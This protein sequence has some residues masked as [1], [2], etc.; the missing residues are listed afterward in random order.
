[1]KLNHFF[2]YLVHID[3][4]EEFMPVT[5]RK[6]LEITRAGLT[7]R[8][9]YR[10]RLYSDKSEYKIDPEE[11]E[12]IKLPGDYETQILENATVLYTY[13]AYIAGKEAL[14]VRKKLM[15]VGFNNHILVIK[16][17]PYPE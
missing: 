3:S 11:I 2:Q 17:V 15:E 7:A 5:H 13:G 12:Q 6:R 9:L 8:N 14:K 10:L 4:L 1:M 16:Y